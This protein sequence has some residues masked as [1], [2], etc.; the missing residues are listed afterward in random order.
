MLQI[1]SSIKT[2]FVTHFLKKITKKT[3]EIQES[4][5]FQNIEESLENF[6]EKAI[7][8]SKEVF[9][10]ISN[11]ETVKKVVE[12]SKEVVNDIKNNES[13]QN[14]VQVTKDKIQEVKENEAV[15]N[16]Y[17]KSVEF[18]GNV[19]NKTMDFVDDISGNSSSKFENSEEE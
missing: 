16:A 1:I 15:Q 3:K 2:N 13:V 18:A 8:K 9:E 7:D 19:K 14:A 4:E 17:N 6:T 12:K 11:N 10:D 5:T